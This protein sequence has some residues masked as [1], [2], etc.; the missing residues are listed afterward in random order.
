MEIISCELFVTL[1]RSTM[2]I[3]AYI[4]NAFLKMFYESGMMV[5]P[6]NPSTQEA[7]AGGSL[8]SRPVW[9]QDSQGYKKK[10]CLKK[11]KKNK[12]LNRL[13]W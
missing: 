6:F 9:V 12:C 4:L 13:Q 8:S 1:I 5:H 7:E 3:G 11:Q 10:P 2:Y